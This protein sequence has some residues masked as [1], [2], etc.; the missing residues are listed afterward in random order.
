MSTKQ[1]LLRAIASVTM[2]ATMAGSV[3]AF[4]ACKT[5]NDPPEHAQHSYTYTPNSDGTTHNGVCNAEGTCYHKNITNEACA[6]TDNDNKCD[7]CQR[8]M[9]TNPTTEFQ[10]TFNVNGG[11]WSGGSTTDK[12]VNTVNGKVTPPEE[13][14]KDADAEFTYTF[15]GWGE[16]T[17]TEPSAV[18]TLNNKTFTADDTLYA[19][20]NKTP[21]EPGP[22][23]GETW[24]VDFATI[25][26]EAASADK[27]LSSDTT[28]AEKLTLHGN[29]S[30][31]AQ[32]SAVGLN[33]NGTGATDNHSVS[34]TVAKAGK[35]SIEVSYH[36]S[37]NDRYLKVFNGSGDIL[38]TTRKMPTTGKGA[39]NIKTVTV[40][41][42][43]TADNTELFIGSYNS[44]I[45]VTKIAV[46]TDPNSTT[47]EITALDIVKTKTSYTLVNANKVIDLT[48]VDVLTSDNAKVPSGWTVTTKL[49][50][51]SAC[52]NE[53]TDAT[54]TSAATYYVKTKAV[55]GASGS[56]ESNVVQVTV[57]LPTAIAASDLTV[58]AD[59]DTSKAEVDMDEISITA[60]VDNEALDTTWT[61]T[62]TVKK[63]GT[64]AQTADRDKVYKLDPG[65]YTV[66]I[67]ANRDGLSAPLT[68]TI[69]ITVRAYSASTTYVE[70]I[71]FA[72]TNGTQAVTWAE[73]LSDETP[74]VT[75]AA[76]QTDMGW[77]NEKPKSDSTNSMSAVVYGLVEHKDSSD[78]DKYFT[79]HVGDNITDVKIEVYAS[80]TTSKKVRTLYL[81]K[82]NTPPTG[83]NGSN[84]S[85]VVATVTVAGKSLEAGETDKYGYVSGQ[86]TDN[87]HKLT[88]ENLE[89]GDYYLVAEDGSGMHVYAIVITYTVSNVQ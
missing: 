31:R 79:I 6:D 35:V 17:T 4:T 48:D 80:H 15:A 43:T 16:E 14:E 10:I 57:A 69:N 39:S 19:I 23:T 67:S 18:L 29:E 50:S 78:S 34:F 64:D 1:K 49:Y 45:D 33:L 60:G 25:Y 58:M 70:T 86:N 68:K 5:D 65:S 9:S 38:G 81:S 89:S 8:D 56:A 20:W 87:L 26:S 72:D 71:K 82:V 55:D 51:D 53:V 44:G 73:G 7:K 84:D 83:Y 28:I 37:N 32:S 88:A 77:K 59:S 24:T 52:D 30:V 36:N 2:A 54:V 47:P 3:F 62:F 11:K 22:V 66:E 85:N 74:D 76:S 75:V 27:S 12:K 13:P 41:L 42:W 40:T 61:K 21:V 46:T 63:D